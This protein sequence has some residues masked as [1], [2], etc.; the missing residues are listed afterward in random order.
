MATQ[1]NPE[2]KDKSKLQNLIM[3]VLLLFILMLLTSGVAYFV[4]KNIAGNNNK[5]VV[6]QSKSN[7]TYDAGEFLTNLSDKGYIRLSLVYLLNSKDVENELELKE[8]E[9][10][11]KIFVILRSETYDSIKDSKGMENLRKKIKESLNQILNDGSIVDVYFTS[12]I[13]N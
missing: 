12:I 10:R 4:A 9:I 5:T 3:I 6:E 8:S 13:V 7:I 11:D 1:N 2:K